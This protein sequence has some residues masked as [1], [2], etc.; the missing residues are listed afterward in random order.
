MSQ[1]QR[2]WGQRA[3]EKEG[4]GVSN[5]DDLQLIVELAERGVSCPKCGAR[6]RRLGWTTGRTARRQ[7]GNAH[8][9]RVWSDA[10]PKL[11]FYFGPLAR[12]PEKS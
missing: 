12:E 2:D 3:P 1:R 4:S 5:V 9:K 10:P 6:W 8:G 7:T 11:V